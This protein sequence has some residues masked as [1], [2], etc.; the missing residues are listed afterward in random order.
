M[1]RLDFLR[2]AYDREMDIVFNNS[3]NYLMTVPKK[4]HEEEFKE[5]KKRADM[6]S[7][8]IKELEG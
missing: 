2:K 7:A 6:L 5:A 4:G 8:W 1:E 3:A